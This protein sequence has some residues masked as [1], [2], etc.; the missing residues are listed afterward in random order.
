[1]REKREEW[2]LDFYHRDPLREHV[3]VCVRF[4]SLRFT[5]FDI[6]IKKKK[7]TAAMKKMNTFPQFRHTHKAQFSL[8]S[9]STIELTLARLGN[10]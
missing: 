7:K 4:V 5:G 2:Q 10:H 6:R 8:P 3:S 1:M 9:F